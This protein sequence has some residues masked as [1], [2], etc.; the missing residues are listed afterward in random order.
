MFEAQLSGWLGPAILTAALAAVGYV[1]KLIISWIGSVVEERRQRQ[2]RLVQLGSLLQATR[3]AFEVQR[4]LL[5]RLTAAI[6][7]RDPAVVH[8]ST[9][10]DDM[11]LNGYSSFTASEKELHAIIRGYTVHALQPGNSALMQWLREDFYFKAY[12]GSGAH[13]DLAGKLS[14]LESHLFL[15]LAKYAI[16]IPNNP[17]RAIIYMD[18]EKRHG[19]PFPHGIENAVA[20]VMK[21]ISGP[22]LVATTAP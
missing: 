14:Q 17:E 16:L 12:A 22:R 18:D 19:V 8:S 1:A 20:A 3:V 9:S 13:A 5:D 15:W 2:A 10:F 7:A 11:I 6:Q 4:D 21:R